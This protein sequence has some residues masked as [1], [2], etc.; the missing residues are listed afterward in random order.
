MVQVKICLPH[1][2]TQKELEFLTHKNRIDEMDKYGRSTAYTK[3]HKFLK[4]DRLK[5]FILTNYALAIVDD[6]L[7]KNGD[8]ELI[9]KSGMTLSNGFDDKKIS[10]RKKWIK[11]I[12]ELG[13][14]LRKLD[15]SGFNTS[16]EIYQ[17]ILNFYKA[18]YKDMNRRWNILN[19][20]TLDALNQEIGRTVGAQFMY[21]LFPDMDKRVTQKIS[22]I[23]GLAVK[24]ADNLSDLDRDFNRGYIN[25]S[26]ENIDKYKL[27]VK[28]K[29]YHPV[30]VEGNIKK[31]KKS[32]LQRVKRLFK[33]ADKIIVETSKKYNKESEKLNILSEGVLKSWLRQAVDSIK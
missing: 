10:E 28:I 27:K 31:Y 7:D 12:A 9:K 15:A 18:D 29:K 13:R 26:K 2:T 32:E 4:G 30:I 6:V 23:Y 25:I 17:E 5:G 21:F 33:K 8:C 1:M 19:Q 16:E 24:T 22:S 11:N 3:L 20:E 14:I